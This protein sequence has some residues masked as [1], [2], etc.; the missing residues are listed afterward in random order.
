MPN[1]MSHDYVVST[2]VDEIVQWQPMVVLS[3]ALY[4]NRHDRSA[5]GFWKWR[6]NQAAVAQEL[7][8]TG[9][10]EVLGALA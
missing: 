10:V 6:E 9:I 1:T 7:V 3:C 5:S 8:S 4:N 2:K